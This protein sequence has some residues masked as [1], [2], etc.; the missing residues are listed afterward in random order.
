[1]TYMNLTGVLLALWPLLFPAIP[2]PQTSC[3]ATTYFSLAPSQALGSQGLPRSDSACA[4]AV[5]VNTPEQRPSN[6][7][8]NNTVVSPPYGFA[9]PG[10][11][12][13]AANVALVTG[14]FKGT[15][16]QIF[17]WAACKWGLDENAIRAEAVKESS[18]YQNAVGDVC[19]PTGQASYGI[20][21]IKNKDCT[22]ATIQG[23]YPATQN[24]TAINADW[25]GARIRSCYDGDITYL[26]PGGVIPIATANGWPYVYWT[27]VGSYYSGAWADAPGLAYSNDVQAILAAEPWLQPGF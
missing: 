24:S 16:S 10:Q 2:L 19:G 7:T 3:P 9:V 14:N 15:T 21:Q 20:L 23:G 18:W 11:P 22:G 13:F 1:M 8:A 17:Q 12:L 26:Y 4:A 27:C 25:F 6:A 5:S